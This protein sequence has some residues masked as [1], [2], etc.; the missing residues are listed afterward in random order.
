MLTIQL[1]NSPIPNTLEELNKMEQMIAQRMSAINA[2]S[3]SLTQS[4]VQYKERGM[5][6]RA[7][8]VLTRKSS[9]GSDIRQLSAKLMEIQAKRSELA[10]STGLH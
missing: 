8:Q 5:A 9:L 7:N 6:I 1:I 10:A 3:N 4:M 2:I